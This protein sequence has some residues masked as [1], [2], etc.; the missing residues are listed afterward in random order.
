M[1]I[2]QLQ[3]FKEL[4]YTGS[5]TRAAANLDISQP[6]LSTRI[7]QLEEE[8]ELVLVD[9]TR[10]PLVI[11]EEG[12]K[13]LEIALEILQRV[14]AIRE[15]PFQRMKEIRGELRIGIIPTLAPYFVPL[16]AGELNRQYP[17]LELV[18]EEQ[19]TSEII[20]HLRAG[21][22]DAGILSTPVDAGNLNIRPLFYE[23]FFLYVSDLHP[24]YKKASVSLRDFDPAELW[25][26]QEGNCFQNQVN[27]ICSLA[28]KGPAARP[29]VYKSNSIESLRRIVESKRGMTFIPELATLMVPSEQEEMIKTLTGASPVREISL[30]YGP[31]YAKKHLLDAFTEVALSQLP[32][33]MKKTPEMWVV[34]SGIKVD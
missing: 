29:L 21:Y 11:T 22:L 20:H 4:V 24:L 23:K 27:A 31:L 2:N 14:E 3:Y 19:I 34:D 1:D 33:S 32:A 6:A 17:E 18:V 30:V 13:V 26:L 28:G 5:F 12:E 15:F 16:F 10:K 9:R 25:Y 8:L 7:R